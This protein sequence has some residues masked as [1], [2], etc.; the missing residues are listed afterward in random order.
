MPPPPAPYVAP[1]LRPLATRS[2][3]SLTYYVDSTG[4]VR[5][6]DFDHGVWVTPEDAPLEVAFHRR[7]DGTT[8]A[9]QV[10]HEAGDRGTGQ[11]SE[12]ATQR[13][14]RIDAY[15][16]PRGAV[17]GRVGEFAEWTVRSADGS[18]VARWSSTQ[19][20]G[21]AFSGVARLDRPFAPVDPTY[22]STWEGCSR[23]TYVLGRLVGLDAGWATRLNG[24][25]G[26]ARALAAGTYTLTVRLNPRG[27]LADGDR[28]NDARSMPIVVRRVAVQHGGGGGGG[29]GAPQPAA[30]RAVR[31]S[32]LP[33]GTTRVVR[34]DAPEGAHVH[35]HADGTTSVHVPA[36]RRREA[37]WMG[38]ALDRI[39]RV[40]AATTQGRASARVARPAPAAVDLPDLR[41]AP[42][43]GIS[44]DVE[45]KR[46]QGPNGPAT[47]VRDVLSFGALTWN[48]GPG[49]L[50]VE[51]F[52]EEGNTLDAYQVFFRDGVRAA[53]QARGAMIWHDAPGHDHF[54]FQSFAR[55]RLTT[56]AGAQVRSSGKNSWCIVDTN[57]VDTTLPGASSLNQDGF[58]GLS[59]GCGMDPGS[60][61]ARLSMS[62]G[63]GDL[64]YQ[65]LAGQGF[66]ITYLA[67]GTYRILIE[68]N[69]DQIIAEG[70]Y[71]NN[72][73]VRAVRLGGTRGRRT[74]SLLPAPTV[75]D[76]AE[77]GFG[78][79]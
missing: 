35:V 49:R 43:F 70:S 64:Y 69:P 18:V 41:S 15:A 71:A 8:Y 58:A 7:W 47:I 10:F 21:D 54:H 27:L 30:R 20:T 5:S 29:G 51:A 59:G 13:E 6:R 52:R 34:P 11:P 37:S 77:G 48:A 40:A 3:A 73:S 36:P 12:I 76:A 38:D 68:A 2:S 24:G 22:P 19:C 62:V 14:Q 75:D 72:D 74:V 65:S 79:F 4:A 57:V 33:P 23:S 46:V 9:E 61:W 39:E 67:N 17:L 31:A 55:Y 45:R 78:F 53:R 66:D 26:P 56:N 25:S 28:T 42:S 32:E 50:E 63:A 44:T 60:L 16:G 1:D